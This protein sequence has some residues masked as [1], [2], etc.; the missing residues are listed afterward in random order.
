M[1]MV[2]PGRV[3]AL[4]VTPD[5]NYCVAAVA[6]KIHVWQVSWM[7]KDQNKLLSS[8]KKYWCFVFFF[9]KIYAVGTH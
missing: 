6:E 3:T 7:D 1:K 5:G 8:P 2:C 9:T 4:A